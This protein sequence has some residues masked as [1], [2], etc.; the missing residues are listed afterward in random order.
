MLLQTIHRHKSKFRKVR[1]DVDEDD[2]NIST[3]HPP[4]ATPACCASSARLLGVA[5]LQ[6]RPLMRG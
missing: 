4:G 3:T 2:V 6:G 1:G 5:I